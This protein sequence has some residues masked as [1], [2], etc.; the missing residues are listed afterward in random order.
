[1][2]AQLMRELEVLRCLRRDGLLVIGDVV[3]IAT[4]VLVAVMVPVVMVSVNR[5]VV[6]IPVLHRRRRRQD[7]RGRLEVDLDAA[8]L[9]RGVA[10][11]AVAAV[12]AARR[13]ATLL[14]GGLRRLTVAR[15]L[16]ERVSEIHVIPPPSMRCVRML[17]I[18]SGL[19]RVA[20]PVF[21]AAITPL[22]RHRRIVVGVSRILLVMV[23]EIVVAVLVKPLVGPLGPVVLSSLGVVV[24]QAVLAIPRP[25]V[26]V[27]LVQ[28][29]LRSTQGLSR[30][31]AVVRLTLPLAVDVLLA[32]PPMQPLLG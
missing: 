12:V 10:R 26:V 6:R 16:G 29:L 7:D 23:V 1:M 15:R 24:A 18:V 31:V 14:G 32:V 4:A 25:V 2:M 28:I 11:A 20:V 5:V 22:A 27:T 19:H 17:K 8:P 30:Q 9:Q 21:I 3:A 13:R